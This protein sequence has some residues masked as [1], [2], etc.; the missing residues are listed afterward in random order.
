[1]AIWAS[2]AED[3]ASPSSLDREITVLN[4]SDAALKASVLAE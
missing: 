1:L 3:D 4:E 2:D